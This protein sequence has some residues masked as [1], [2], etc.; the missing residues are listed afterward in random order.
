MIGFFPK[1]QDLLFEQII[2]I[3]LT[4]VVFGALFLAL[5]FT[6]NLLNFLPTHGNIIVHL[7]WRDIL[8]GALIYFK[9]S[10]DFAILIGFLMR[11]NPGWKSRIAIEL[12]T[13]LGNG[14]GT[15]LILCFW[16]IFKQLNVLLAIM[17][18]LSAL[19]LFE[20]AESGLQHFSS[21]RFSFGF[22]RRL[23]NFLKQILS[24]ISSVTKPI[25]SKILPNFSQ[26]LQGDRKLKWPAL[27]VFA[28]SMPFILG[29]DDFAGYVPLF[30]IV[31]VFGF[32]TGVMGA[33]MLL[34]VGLF[35]NPEVTIKWFKNQWVSFLGT[36]VFIGL[37]FVAIFEALKIILRF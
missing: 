27:L 15:I 19:V 7:Y 32:A 3:C 24:A 30:N 8:V 4:I 5:Y 31:N 37:A 14:A 35:A 18:L 6:I 9:T 16:V 23:F 10:V 12:G 2:P 13:A 28:L 17:V 11:A 26:T 21:W 33:H 34:N 1:K 22:K 20:M 36:L 29:L 25:T